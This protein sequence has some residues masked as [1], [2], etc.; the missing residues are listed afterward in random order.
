MKYSFAPL[1]MPDTFSDAKS[2]K[3]LHSRLFFKP[4]GLGTGA[5]FDK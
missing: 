4:T 2:R 5:L 3:V 1:F